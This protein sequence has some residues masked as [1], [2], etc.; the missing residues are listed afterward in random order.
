MAQTNIEYFN[1]Y[2]KMFVNSIIDIF[3]EYKEVL[4]DYYKPLL[5]NET[6]NEDKYVKRFMVKMKDYKNQISEKD[7]T[8]FENSVYVLKNV[9]FKNIWSNT[10]LSDTNREKIWEYLQTMYV[11]GESII[12][13]CD[14]IQ[15]LVKS[16][17]KIR[18][19]DNNDDDMKGEDKAMFQMLK[20]LSESKK[21]DKLPESFF[22]DGMIGKLA[23]QLTSE[24]NM[25]DLNLNMENTN[26]VDDVFGSLMSGE[27]PM[28]FMNLLQS[29]GKN[30]ESKISSGDLDQGKLV[31]EAQAMMGSLNQ[32]N[33]M[34]NNLFKQFGNLGGSGDSDDSEASGFNME[35]GLDMMQSM[36]KNFGG[37]NQNNAQTRGREDSRT[38][39]TRDRL[40]RKL[41]AR[42]NQQ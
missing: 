17:Q 21:D 16:F 4:S 18:S 5:E 8:I 7:A 28:K 19:G 25:D 9:D 11:L 15:S 12:S 26:S 42:K 23:Q 20:N 13:D 24:I 39:S 2:L 33:P 1:Y 10:E 41:E 34:L 3:P 35:Q 29:V 38:S 27:N 6:S 30:I 22:K 32:D 40:R 36:M 37:M 14:R 31:E